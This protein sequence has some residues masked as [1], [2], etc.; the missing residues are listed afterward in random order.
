MGRDIVVYEPNMNSSPHSEINVGLL[1]VFELIW[2]KNTKF[3][4]G[5]K[6]HINY[7]KIKKNI[8]NWNLIN[9]KTFKYIPLFFLINDLFLIFKM[10][11]IFKK[12][13]RKNTVFVF[14][15]IM[16]FSHI[17]ISRYNKRH[18]KN[19]LLCLHGQME[20]YLKD[21]KIGI[22]K[23]YYRLCK[24]VFK[25]DDDNIKYIV[26]GESIKENIKHLFSNECKIITI[27][28]PY[29]YPSIRKN[30]D[31]KN[32]ITLGFIG[33]ADKTKNISELYKLIDILKYYIEKD[34]IE[35][36]VVGRFNYNIP[37]KYERL[38]T[39]FT[40]TVAPE[41]FQ[42]EINTLDFAISFTGKEYYRATP[43]GTFF[44]CVKWEIPL[45]TLE[46]D[47][48]NYYFNKYGSMGRSFSDTSQMGL[49]IIDELIQKDTYIGQI[50][51]IEKSYKRLKD[52]ISINSLAIKLAE[53]LK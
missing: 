16:P 26:F 48:T 44:D 3:F 12:H 2:E 23:N 5:D 38:F 37:L 22:S 52:D 40:S 18:K 45:L 9:F 14:L 47:F 36:K 41:K 27:D 7:L 43:S 4:Y 31:S 29:I 33:R 46:N 15:G 51:E 1:S 35:I 24:N 19:I 11:K 17:Y 28:Q 8:E 32:K 30:I 39:Y 49:W 6:R 34:R 20:A 10:R 42:Q 13:T 21:T 53:Q 25:E 50:F